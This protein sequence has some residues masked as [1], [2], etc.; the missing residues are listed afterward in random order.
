ML[1]SL[2]LA[3]PALFASAHAAPAGSARVA[4][5][6]P[7]AGPYTIIDPSCAVEGTAP[8]SVVGSTF[9]LTGVYTGAIVDECANSVLNGSGYTVTPTS[10]TDFG[11]QVNTT[12]GVT[13]ENVVVGGTP[14]EAVEVINATDT[15]VV[16]ATS[17]LGMDFG[18][19][20]THDTGLTISESNLNDTADAGIE[21][22]GAQD[23]TVSNSYSSAGPV[24]VAA[25]SS[26]GIVVTNL[27]ATGDEDGA[28]LLTDSDVQLTNDN[29]SGET[30]SGILEVYSDQVTASDLNASGSETGA[31]AELSN[32]TVI[33]DS[34]LSAESDVGVEGFVVDGFNVSGSNLSGAGTYGVL[35]QLGT[36]LSFWNDSVNGSAVDGFD[37]ENSTSVSI[38]ASWAT[39]DGWNGLRSVSTGDLSVVG[40]VFDNV[41][42]DGG[43]G[44]ELLHSSDVTLSGDDEEN[45]TTG[46]TDEGSS[47][48]A[49]T[50]ANTTY[51]TLGFLFDVDSRVT[52]TN[53]T[54]L[55]VALGAEFIGTNG[56]SVINETL[57]NTTADGYLD[58]ESTGLTI[59][60]STA[61]GP[62]YSPPLEGIMEATA[63]GTTLFNDS[64]TNYR[65]GVYVT[66]GIR[67]TLDAVN[68][69]SASLAALYILAASDLTVENGNF[70]SSGIGFDLGQVGTASILGNTFYN[71]TEE[72]EFPAADQGGLSVYWNN[73]VRGPATEGW[74][75][76]GD[77][78]TAANVVFADGYPGGGNY[79]SNWTTP[80][81]ESG[82]LQ[83]LPGGDGIV[84]FPLP[85]AGTLEDP[86]PLTRAVTIP[87][88]TTQFLAVGLPGGTSWTVVFNGTS[89]STASN[90]L[91][92]STRT[93]AQ[94]VSL[95]YS[96][97]APSG[98][99]VA[100]AS[101]SVETNGSPLLVVL[102]FAPVTYPVAFTQSGLAAGTPWSVTVNGT[103]ISS[104][105]GSASLSL[106]NGTYNYTVNPT[107]GY[108][109]A[110]SSGTLV[111]ASAGN[112]TALLFSAVEYTVDFTEHGLPEGTVWSVTFDGVTKTLPSA[113][114]SFAIANGSY[115]YSV[116]NVSGY[117]LVG[118][119]GSQEVAGPGASVQVAFTANS[120]SGFGTGSGLFWVLVAVIAILAV[121][122]V[123]AVLMG[124]KKPPAAAPAS[125]WTPPATSATA[126]ASTSPPPGG[127]TTPPPGATG[128]PP[129]WK[130]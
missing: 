61:S 108:T 122:L 93:A 56:D 79:W 26:Y 75:V 39:G 113:T 21:V 50:G 15:T 5:I 43:N 118:G 27:T 128:P 36:D 14:E 47:Q 23:V 67:T 51:D 32:D 81:L 77:G 123:A 19:V 49:V 115:Q 73:F 13:V 78:A 121:A 12:S 11:V 124:R 64:F 68:V 111:V 127:A 98:W 96:V 20:G 63:I 102:D 30:A 86:Y 3:S 88:T 60:D 106:P 101:G 95:D 94:N 62:A 70:S 91:I 40:S 52:V 105:S 16:N 17:S 25:D 66:E 31:V 45:D 116:G 24:G 22:G 109:V 38:T 125:A 89:Q 92:F 48:V 84:D 8:L 29:F 126:A 119:S 9:T 6:T 44:T 2:V 33:T 71:D 53:S 130:E 83:N 90:S 4:E 76:D 37:I 55:E 114:I 35:A 1:L 80:D 65:V 72:F 97:V 129:N 57:Y 10:G 110:P 28:L 41:T 54:A 34:N 103:T 99:T 87:D 46:V 120:T 117:S 104:D 69:T 58:I 85:I 74:V 107:A 82:P 112:T 100:P 42:S 18:I 59:S 7:S